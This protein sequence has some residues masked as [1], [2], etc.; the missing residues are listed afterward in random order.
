MT[1]QDHARRIVTGVPP[2][3]RRQLAEAPLDAL[4][5][6]GLQVAEIDP[7]TE[8]H[9]W[10][11]GLSTT[12]QGLVL[13]LATPNSRRENF[14]LLHEY[15]HTLVDADE[16]ALVWLADQ[17]D[18]QRITEQLCNAIASMLLVPSE[19]IDSIIGSGPVL[20]EHLLQ[21]HR[22]T[23][24]S[25]AA[26]A[27]AL[28]RR[29]TTEGAVLLVD[30]TTQTVAHAA[31]VGELAVWPWKNQQVPDTHPLTRIQPGDHLQTSSWWATPW[32]DRQPYYLDATASAKRA[33]AILAM[34]DLWNIEKFH[35][36]ESAPPR[37]WRPTSTR[38]CPC[39]YTGPMTGWP[40]PTCH[41]HFCPQCKRCLCDVRNAAAVAC[42]GTCGLSYQP[43]ALVGGLCSGCR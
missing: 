11:D 25:Q 5:S 39:G 8:P 14:T 15:A 10:C 32:G 29:L 4:A 12:E 9:R 42:R 33:Y 17:P 6:V 27:V 23:E 16:E 22:E 20:A 1:L 18:D 30:R 35:G 41:K 7:G 3:L 24:A 40:C 21:L 28:A 43:T 2:E 37:E 26:I 36:G 34:T 31:I 13:Y 19:T 38:S